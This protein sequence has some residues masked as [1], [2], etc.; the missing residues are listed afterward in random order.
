MQKSVALTL[1]FVKYVNS[2]FKKKPKH[3]HHS[4]PPHTP[5]QFTSLASFMTQPTEI[6]SIQNESLFILRTQGNKREVFA[7]A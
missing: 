6:H 5:K 3:F 7:W 2:P 4:N 1:R